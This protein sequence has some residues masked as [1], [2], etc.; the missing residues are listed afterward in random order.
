MTFPAHDVHR[1]RPLA[2]VAGVIPPLDG[3]LS[4]RRHD[5]HRASGDFGNDIRR[6]PLA[7]LR[8]GSDRDVAAIVALARRTGLPVVARGQGHSV[9]GQALVRD[10]I[11][12]DMSCLSVIGP[13]GDD[14]VS[15][16]AGARWNA[17]VDATLPVGLTPPVLPDHL[18]L[19]V[20]GTV[21]AGGIG[22]ASHRH[23]CVADNVLQMQVVTP[24]GDLVDCSPVHRADVFDA[25]R[26][27]Q[28]RHGIITR[29]TL[30][31][32]PAP[33]TVRRWLCVHDDRSRFLAEQLRLTGQRRL[34]HLT[35]QARW[36]GDRWEYVLE[37]MAAGEVPIDGL[38]EPS[39]LGYREF[40]DRLV[41]VE[42][43]LRQLGSWQGDP[44]P[45]CTVML[46]GRRA[47][48]VIAE[49]LARTAPEDLGATG[50]VLV[51]PI[52]TERLAAPWVPRARNDEV[53]V[54]F[55]MQRTA[56]RGDPGALERMRRANEAL[57]ATARRLGGAVYAGPTAS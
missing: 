13:P 15:V 20:G 46:P 14:R 31:L 43:Q 19:S 36:V 21:S 4:I 54:V 44:H 57:R 11:V 6:R 48:N 28:G 32:A 23:G 53:T 9:D 10:G 17:V 47:G 37:A 3:E 2:G 45:R 35:G 56:P 7:V 1:R 30:R 33:R 38:G 40:L 22:G 27:T 52:P 16:Q 24:A 25:V 12:V 42:A 39:T 34:D 26:A 41:P 18:G 29:V 5:L 49:V 51:Y 50:S 8:P 55:G